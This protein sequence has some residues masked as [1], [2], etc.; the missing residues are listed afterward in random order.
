MNN[1]YR[2]YCDHGQPIYYKGCSGCK[3]VREQEAKIRYDTY[4]K[5]KRGDFWDY[6][7]ETF[8]GDIRDPSYEH[9]IPKEFN[10]LRRSKSS[11]ELKKEYYV[12][13]ITLIKEVL[14]VCFRGYKIYM[15]DFALL[16]DGFFK[17]IYASC[18]SN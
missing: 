16:F 15:R 13:Y 9:E 8:G 14:P 5:K 4:W 2:E 7:K 6:F 17:I 10:T 12:E 11:E 18:S 3:A 1:M